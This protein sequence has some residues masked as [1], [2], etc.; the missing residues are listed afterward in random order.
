[1]PRLLPGSLD[2]TGAVIDCSGRRQTV[3]PCFVPFDK[4]SPARKGLM[5]QAGWHMV[6][7]AA[8]W[9]GIPNHGWACV[10]RI[11]PA[12]AEWE[13]PLIWW[14][15]QEH[16]DEIAQRGLKRN[17]PPYLNDQYRSRY[18]RNG[19]GRLW[20]DK[21]FPDVDCSEQFD[22]REG[23]APRIDALSAAGIIIRNQDFDMVRKLPG[24]VTDLKLKEMTE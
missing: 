24:F 4:L 13:M 14:T 17:W 19:R 15:A 12:L 10:I 23:C 1:M 22:R 2:A 21:R 18:G 6:R 11:V 9:P 7:N 16:C 3:G 8:D 5:G 20:R